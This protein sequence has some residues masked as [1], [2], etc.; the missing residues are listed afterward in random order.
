[1][2]KKIEERLSYIKTNKDIG[3]MT[4]VVAGY[5]NKQTTIDLVKLMEDNGVDFVE[6][7]IP[8]SDP[9][10]DGPTIMKANQVALDNG[11]KLPDAFEVASKITQSVNIPIL[12][13]TYINIPYVY[14]YEK[15]IKDAINSGI[16]GVIVPDIPFDEEDNILPLLKEN[17][18]SPIYVISPDIREER[19]QKVATIAEDFIYTTLKIGITGARDS[20]DAKSIE[21]LQKIK[22]IINLPI[23]SGF[24]ISKKEHIDLLKGKTDIAVIGSHILNLFNKG[25]FK[26]VE[27]FLQQIG[28]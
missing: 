15:F 28:K 14:G 4:H 25:G 16:S 3:L 24:G 5:P 7:Q 21:F 12:F 19:L 23:A 27:H 17:K 20:I 10:A 13:M 1:M 18:L 2:N 6:I 26:E 9:L 11:F 8:F 22:N